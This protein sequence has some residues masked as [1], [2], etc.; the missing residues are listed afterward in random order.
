[1]EY[2][3][4]FGSKFP[5]E[6]IPVGTKKDIDDISTH[7]INQYY[8]Y[9]DAG[10]VTEANK[11]YNSNKELLEQYSIN[12][13]YINFIEEELWNMSV[14]TLKKTSTIIT[15][16]EPAT[17]PRYGF[18][19][20]N[21]NNEENVECT[22]QILLLYHMETCVQDDKEIVSQHH[23]KMRE[24]KYTEATKFLDDNNYQVITS[25]IFNKIEDKFNKFQFLF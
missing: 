18:W 20:Q 8:A 4:N 22:Y 19:L 14:L 16:N 5:E 15:D 10:N 1:M 11:L 21:I 9:I 12:M 17:Q 3:R 2:S 25:F 23:K 6:L 24:N 7:L 13:N